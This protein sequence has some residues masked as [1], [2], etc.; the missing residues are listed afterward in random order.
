MITH[1]CGR[2][3]LT[4]ITIG[5]LV[6]TIYITASE[7]IIMSIILQHTIR[8]LHVDKIGGPAGMLAR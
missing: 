2:V 3:S 7:E 4:L 8:C 5:K 6:T 1:T